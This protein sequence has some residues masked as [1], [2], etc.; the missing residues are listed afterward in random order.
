MAALYLLLSHHLPH[1]LAPFIVGDIDEVDA[2]GQRGHVDAELVA[3]ALH[4]EHLLPEHVEHFGLPQVLACDGDEACGGVGVDCG[5][6][7]GYITF[8]NTKILDLSPLDGL[9]GQSAITHARNADRMP[10]ASKVDVSPSV[11]IP[12]FRQ[13]LKRKTGVVGIHGQVNTPLGVG[14]L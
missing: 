8:I 13:M 2:C 12:V 9:I 6:G 14:P 10:C 7:V 5:E 4:A 1:T 3:L 11:M